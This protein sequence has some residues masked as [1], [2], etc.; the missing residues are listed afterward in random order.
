MIKWVKNIF[1]LHHFEK[2]CHKRVFSATEKG[3]FFSV[4]FPENMLYFTGFDDQTA[5]P[6]ETHK[7]SMEK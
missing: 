5:R 1:Q 2:V 4:F 7:E 3:A 6:T